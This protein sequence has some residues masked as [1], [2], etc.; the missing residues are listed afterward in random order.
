M[1]NKEI[2]LF[3]CGEI[4]YQV[5]QTLGAENVL[6]FCDNNQAFYEVGRWGKQ[7]IS[8]GQLMEEYSNYTVVVCVRLPKAYLIAAQLDQKGISDYW[9]YPMVEQDV[10]G[11]SADDARRFLCDRDAMYQMRMKSYQNKISD[12][13]SQLDYMKEHS[14]IRSMK[15][16]VGALRERQLALADLGEFFC[17]AVE[18]LG[19]RPILCAGNLL[20]YVRNGG[21]VPWDDDMD[22]DLIREE[23]ERLREY[24]VA[25]RDEDG[26]VLFQWNGKTERLF[27]YEHYKMFGLKKK[28]TEEIYLTVDFFALDYYADNY[29]FQTLREDVKQIQ[30][31]V[32]G[33]DSM[34]KRI[35]YVREARQK[36]PNIVKKSN[37]I[38]FGFDNM[39]AIRPHDI[40]KTM[41]ENIVFPL[42]RAEFEGKQFWVPNC[43]EEY[44]AYYYKDIWSFPDDVGVQRHI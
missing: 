17:R 35:N 16:A 9:L 33:L 42:E 43:P 20:G 15:P 1:E 7:V 5:L 28:V 13:E 4:G 34:E 40:G 3:G 37:S 39:Q 21:F 10:C 44:L 14:D 18:D 23:Y 27:F 22:F 36:N 25:R 38:F 24:C 8:L 32:Y 30:A 26:G 2:V 19:V 12:L 41:P 11:L 6:C 31:D 29:P